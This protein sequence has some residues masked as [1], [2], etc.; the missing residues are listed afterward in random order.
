MRI[1]ALVFLAATFPST[2]FADSRSDSDSS[3]VRAE[4][5]HSA[6]STTLRT[7]GLSKPVEILRDRWGIAHIYAQSEGDLFFAQG[8]SAARDRLFQFELWRIQATGTAAEIFGPSELKR[9]IGAR[10]H[11]FRGDLKK[12]LNHYHPRGESIINAFVRG[13]NAYIAETERNPKLLPI[14]FN[15]LGIKP[16]PW[17]VDVVISRHQGLLGNLT[18]EVDLARYLPALGEEKVRRMYRFQGGDPM[19]TP[20]SA[21]ELA[22]IPEQVLELYSAFR[23]PMKFTPEQIVADYRN[24]SVSYAQ[25]AGNHTPDLSLTLEPNSG[26]GSNNWVIHGSRTMDRAPIMANDPHRAITTPSLRYW[27]HLVAPGWNVIG[28]GEPVLPGVSIGHNE[29][30]AWGL[31]IFGVDSEDLYVYDTNPADA[32]Q[33]RY[34]GKWESMRI[35]EDSIAVK[36]AAA[37]AVEYK[38]TRHGPVLFE[39]K[40]R[41][42]AYALRAAWM[43]E[44]GAPYLASLRMNQSRSWEEFREAC[45]YNRIPSES[46]VWADPK[47]NIGFQATGIQPL[48]PNWSGLLPVP[49]DGRYEWKG[50][51]PIQKFPNEQNPARGYIATANNF[52]LSL[53]YPHT[54]SMPFLWND[55]YRYARINEVLGSG[56]LF[57]VAEVM[58]LQ[59]D[60]LSLPARQLVPLLRGI[61]LEGSSATARDLLLKWDFVLDQDSVAASVYEMWKQRLMEG[62]RNLVL[63]DDAQRA[64]RIKPFLTRVVDAVIAPDGLFGS[65]PVAGRDELV[66]RTFNEAVA[67]LTKR[68]GTD[69]QTWKYGQ[70]KFHHVNIK[71]ALS[72]VVKPE[73]RSLLDTSSLPRGGDNDTVSATV[74]DLQAHGG[75]FKIIVDTANWDSAAGQ[76]TPGQSGDPN[77]PFY[78]NLFELWAQGKYFPV[79]YSRPKIEAVTAERLLLTP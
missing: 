52:L 62:F 14:E 13:V 24:D 49:G 54:Q 20:D 42:K 36:G 60:D 41:H 47:G 61:K 25:L 79:L 35:V 2:I 29:Y 75:S 39:D 74:G 66:Q 1:A 51:L 71:H 19:L 58:R 67:E 37:S 73:L 9:D 44:G 26:I 27:V 17:T 48:R 46:M 18:T 15:L 57:N 68:F 70:E 38:Y 21:L 23:G 33:Y 63:V 7:D 69:M 8:Y 10:L 72:S 5:P 28:A 16:R 11:R 3:V 34:R 6:Q 55:G 76:N 32:N 77:S 12:E 30:G 22:A 31:T 40:Q 56:R 53:D 43:E 59:N 78:R 45:T 64:L 65:D 4:A 50:F